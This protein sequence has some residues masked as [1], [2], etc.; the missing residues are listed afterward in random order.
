MPP[1]PKELA[2]AKK[3]LREQSK[4]I[5]EIERRQGG[6]RASY[7][8]HRERAAAR[9]AELSESGRDIGN[10]PAVVNPARKEAARLARLLRARGG[11]TV[12]VQHR[13]TPHWPIKT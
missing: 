12:E 4:I 9:A 8:S 11:V 3:R 5:R 13:E 10:L 2:E 1:T 6:P 7:Q